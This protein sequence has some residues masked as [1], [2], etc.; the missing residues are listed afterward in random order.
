[1]FID[2]YAHH[3][4]EI[5]ATLAAARLQVETSNREPGRVVA[6]FQPHRYSRT[7]AFL[8]DFAQSF[9]DADL[10]IN[11]EIY[12]ASEQNLGQTSGQQVADAIALY[13]PKVVYQPALADVSAYLK[14]VLVPGDLVMF[15]GAG[16][17]NRII[18]D[19][20][21]F[22]QQLEQSQDSTTTCA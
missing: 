3:P 11:T 13:H 1:L 15:L 7:Q 4:S 8:Q 6:V 20:M 16:N 14:S 5:Q 2:D 19:L 22:F 12:S 18:P 9:G 10:V 17:L 21:I